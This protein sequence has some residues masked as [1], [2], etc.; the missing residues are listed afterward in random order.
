LL[1]FDEINLNG[2][3]IKYIEHILDQDKFNKNIVMVMSYVMHN[4]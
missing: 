1:I 2:D 3:L 4:S